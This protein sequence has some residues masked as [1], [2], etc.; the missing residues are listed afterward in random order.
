MK[1]V[2]PLNTWIPSPP[3][4]PLL[5]LHFKVHGLGVLP[6][7]VA[8]CAY[9]LSG[10]CVLYFF[11]SQGWHPGMATYYDA[12]IQGLAGKENRVRGWALSLWCRLLK[13]CKSTSHQPSSAQYF[14][15]D[16]LRLGEIM[17][18]EAFPKATRRFLIAQG[19]LQWFKVLR[20]REKM[21]D[22][23]IRCYYM[24]QDSHIMSSFFPEWDL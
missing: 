4:P 7:G 9:I 19:Q 24:S 18:I 12:P 11:E 2:P 1:T 21:K 13:G 22:Q 8:G 15:N 6:D 14:R 16:H 3:H 5:T 17:G 20:R 10:I 23:S